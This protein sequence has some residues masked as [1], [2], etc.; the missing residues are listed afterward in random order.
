MPRRESLAHTSNCQSLKEVVSLNEKRQ[1]GQTGETLVIWVEAMRPL[2]DGG[3]NGCK[4]PDFSL[5]M[6]AVDLR[7]QQIGRID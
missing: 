4:I 7:P 6:V 2:E 3:K 1:V 5:M